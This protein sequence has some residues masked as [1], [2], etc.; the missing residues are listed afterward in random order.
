MEKVLGKICEEMT[1]ILNV[2]NKPHAEK[3]LSLFDSLIWTSLM[4]AFQI[5]L[6]GTISRQF[7]T[8]VLKT[9][10]YGNAR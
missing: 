6:M 4:S 8:S 7:Y 1:E 9:A 3:N 10:F 2:Q 5:V